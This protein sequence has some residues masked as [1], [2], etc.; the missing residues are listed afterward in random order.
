[1]EAYFKLP[2][3]AALF[4]IGLA[5]SFLSLTTQV[6]LVGEA[7]LSYDVPPMTDVLE[8]L[9]MTGELVRASS[10]VPE[11]VRIYFLTGSSYEQYNE[12]G[13]LPDTFI[14]HERAEV[15]VRM[16]SFIL[17]ENE[18]N[19]PAEVNLHVEVY[20]IDMPYAI[21]SIPSYVITLAAA[22]LLMGRITARAREQ[23]PKIQN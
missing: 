20:E 8:E 7:T 2:F 6:E 11:G 23:K 10:D 22:V 17:I 21:L 19:E 12:T 13:I 4:A 5:L 15:E 16:P 18:L 1:L 14:D 3:I 9:N